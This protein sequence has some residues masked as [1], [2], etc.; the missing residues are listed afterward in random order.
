MTI[1]GAKIDYL[2]LAGARLAD[3]RL[4]GVSIGEL[5]LGQAQ[6]RHVVLVDCRVDRLTVAG[7]SL[8][9]ADL[10]GADLGRVEGIAGLARATISE[11][12][13]MALAPALAR[14]LQITIG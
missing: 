14:E 5:D 7:A 4:E 11:E 1:R 6:A 13:A 10:R 8:R 9:E 3:V 2:S 12:Q